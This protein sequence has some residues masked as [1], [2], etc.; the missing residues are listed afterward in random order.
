MI[1]V[2]HA[3]KTSF[4]KREGTVFTFFIDKNFPAFEGH[5]PGMP[6]LPAIA[7]IEIALF[8]IRDILNK[9]V[10]ILEIKKSKFIKPVLADS[11]I[12]VLISE[13]TAACC[14]ITIKDE[15]NIYSQISILVG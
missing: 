14:H 8:C 9:N 4:K 5:F 1:K 10:S 12:S 2:S 13:N 6:L 7:Q 11:E 15:K 3:I